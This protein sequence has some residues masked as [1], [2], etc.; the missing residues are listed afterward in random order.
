MPLIS[1]LSRELKELSRAAKE[2]G[3]NSA[4]MAER[5]AD[6]T[7]Q[8]AV[9]KTESQ[10]AAANI[11]ALSRANRDSAKAF[12]EANRETNAAQKNFDGLARPPSNPGNARRAERQ[13]AAIA[14]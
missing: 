14:R 2:S 9:L 5:L 1:E 11:A 7:A 3:D 6:G 13:P 8:L 4:A 10:A 12:T